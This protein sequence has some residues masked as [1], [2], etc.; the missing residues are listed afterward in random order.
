[1]RSPQRR[2][3]SSPLTPA[4]S[5]MLDHLQ[6]SGLRTNP[7]RTGFRRTVIKSI[8][9]KDAATL[10]RPGRNREYPVCDQKG[11]AVWIGEVGIE[12]GREIRAA[13]H[14]AEAR[15]TKKRFLEHVRKLDLPVSAQCMFISLHCG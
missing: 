5:T 8:E 13:K 15:A 6:S 10:T 1:M 14:H 12:S 7:R 4:N 3:C 9:E 11:P 2:S